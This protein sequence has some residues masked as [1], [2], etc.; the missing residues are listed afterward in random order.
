[1]KEPACW[2]E[3]D[4]RG[5]AGDQCGRSVSARC[6]PHPRQVSDPPVRWRASFTGWREAPSPMYVTGA[7]W[8]RARGER[9]CSGRMPHARRRAGNGH[10][11]PYI[12]PLYRSCPLAMRAAGSVESRL[13]S[14]APARGAEP[15]RD[16]C[17][18]PARR[19][20]RC[21]RSSTD[22]PEPHPSA[23]MN[24]FPMLPRNGH[25]RPAGRRPF[26]DGR[27]ARHP[28]S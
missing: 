28:A 26:G 6:V 4:S 14:P 16:L 18:G 2:Y 20:G 13:C 19:L 24:I 23:A 5:S 8:S 11:F 17:D 21:P 22:A 10:V 12:D 27:L 15:C 3:T 1:M 9:Q 25:A 7:P